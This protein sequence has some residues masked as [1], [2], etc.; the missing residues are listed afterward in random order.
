MTETVH[1]DA[2]PA[3]GGDVI[4]SDDPVDPP[5]CEDCGAVVTTL[6]TKTGD[7]DARADGSG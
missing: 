5:T 4:D 2:C 3:C 7:D 1:P 6:D